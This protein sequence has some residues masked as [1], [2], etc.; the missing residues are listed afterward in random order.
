MSEVNLL[1]DDLAIMHQGRILY[2]GTYQAFK[3]SMTEKTLEDQFIQL[4]Q[5]AKP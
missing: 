4:V 5:G 3:E 1:S 2:N